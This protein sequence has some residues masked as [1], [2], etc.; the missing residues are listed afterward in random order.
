M[1]K[2]GIVIWTGAAWE[3]WGPPSLTSGIGGSETAAI[4]MA[5]ELASLGHQVWCIGDHRDYEGTH[6]GV[7]Y[8]PYQDVI[9]GSLPAIDCD[10]FISSRDKKAY[11]APVNSKKKVLWVHDLHVGDDWDKDLVHY[12]RFFCLSKYAKQIF[13]AYYEHVSE[14]KIYITRNGI[15]ADRYVQLVPKGPKP[16]FAYSSSPDRGLDVLLHMWPEIRA[17]APEAELHVYYGFDTWQKM[18]E[19]RKLKSEILKVQFFQSMVTNKEKQG[20]FYH[21]R[22]GQYTLAQAQ[23][24]SALWL[25]PTAFKE[26]YCIT[27]LESQAACAIP[28]TTALG[29]LNETVRRGVLLSPPNT[30]AIYR[31][32]FVNTV[33]SFLTDDSSDMRRQLSA[34][35]DEGREWAMKQTWKSLAYDWSVYFERLLAP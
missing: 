7:K 20:I 19:L 12:D 9:A 28:I 25:Y 22:V 27:A 26:T 35:R 29:G 32:A 14:D 11:L 4:H 16:K 23:L 15:D 2:L 21:G 31:E 10:I 24:S 6:E 17:F 34:M 18:A 33:K 3:Q 1:K 30:E 5:R 13:M 8:V